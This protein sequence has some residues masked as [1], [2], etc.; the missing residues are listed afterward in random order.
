MVA[1]VRPQLGSPSAR[2]HGALLGGRVDGEIPDGR[3]SARQ[4]VGWVPGKLDLAAARAAG[5]V[6]EEPPR[7]SLADAQDLLQYFGRLQRADDAD[8]SA[9][10]P[11]LG[12]V[13]NG[14]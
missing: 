3:R 11:D 7:Q 10:H 2:P 1:M 4:R 14:P 8:G 9:Q 6:D 12:A 13:G 5:I